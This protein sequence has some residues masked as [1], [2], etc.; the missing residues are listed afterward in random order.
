[1]NPPVSFGGALPA[2][3]RLRVAEVSADHLL[4]NRIFSVRTGDIR[5]RPFK[6]LRSQLRKIMQAR[7]AKLIGVTSASP[8]VGKSFVA[9]N[10]AIAMA[11]VAEASVY[12]IDIDLRRPALGPRFGVTDHPGLQDYLTGVTPNLADVAVRV[13]DEQLALITAQDR[14]LASAEL[15][16]SPQADAL[17]AAAR[18]LPEESVAI[19]DMPPIFA[20]DDAVIIAE[21]LDG[22]LVVVED[23]LTTRKQVQETIRLLQPTPCLGTVLNRYKV[24]ILDDEYGYNGGYGYGAYYSS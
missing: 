17:F 18:A 21:R 20:D 9:A 22:V 16:A 13:N 7:G 3:D 19:F 2:I 15:L 11:R 23:G 14:G 10:L 8:G 24:G 5:A 1:M 12:L 6:M 4:E